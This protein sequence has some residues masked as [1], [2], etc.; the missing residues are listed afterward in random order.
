[1]NRGLESN[2]KTKRLTLNRTNTESNQKNM[3]GN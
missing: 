1:M 3:V 2:E